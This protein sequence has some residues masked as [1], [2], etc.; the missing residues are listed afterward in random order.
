VLIALAS[1]WPAR[2][3]AAESAPRLTAVTF[4]LLHGASA[5]SGFSW[6]DHELDRRL[7]M[8]T[9]ALRALRADVIG[10]QEASVSRRHGN[11][12][13]R[14]AERLGFHH[15]HAA[16]RI[17]ISGLA[18]LDRLLAW[19]IDFSE[20][21]AIVSRFPI[22]AWRVHDLPRCGRFFDVRAVLHAELDT[23]WGRMHV[24]STHTSRDSCQIP[25]VADLVRQHRGPLPSLV[26]GDFNSVEGSEPIT[27]LREQAGFVDAFRTANP[28]AP[29][30]TVWQRV[31]A[32]SSTVL[33]RVDYVFVV[34]GR[35]A[36]GTVVSSRVVLN[37][38][39]RLPDGRSLW[40]SD[41]YAV[42]AEVEIGRSRTREAITGRAAAA[43]RRGTGWLLGS[44]A[45][46]RAPR[47]TSSEIR[48]PSRRS[49]GSSE[50]VWR[51]SATPLHRRARSA[52]RRAGTR[53]TAPSS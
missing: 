15:A 41:H 38:P 20:G 30:F 14:L 24:F 46:L 12:A 17:R 35:E 2:S 4:N 32:E 50:I 47:I 45:R 1:G 6:N 53:D 51:G 37:S 28:S 33:R 29:G 16:G 26:M 34:A 25:A 13:G 31:D 36:M 49:N 27:R 21:P 10:L 40:P 39:Q 11:V 7:D 22:V 18:P 48:G 8:V 52:R 42:L 3:V 43:P 9:S 44:A 5:S 23:P 19:L